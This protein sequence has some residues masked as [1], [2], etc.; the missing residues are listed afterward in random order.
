MISAEVASAEALPFE[1]ESFDGVL[2][3]GVLYYLPYRDIL[4]SIDEIHRV[5]RSGGRALVMMKSNDD[6]RSLHST[7]LDDVSY[8]VER[9]AKGMSWKGDIGMTLTLL[10][11][12][13]MKT[14]FQGFRNVVIERSTVSLAD[15]SFN[16]DEWMVYAGK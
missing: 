12:E 4:K 15:G 16:D 8:R 2:S 3:F 7:R 11:R 5:L 13:A 9:E 14:C 6:A 10:G 1:D